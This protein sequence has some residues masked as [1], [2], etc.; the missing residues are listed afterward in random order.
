MK[1]IESIKELEQNLET[2]EFYLSEGTNSENNKTTKLIRAGACFVAYKIDD[3]LRFAPSRFVGYKNNKLEKHFNS[4]KDGR[5][6]NVIIEKLLDNKLGINEKLEISFLKYCRNL[7]IEPYKKKRKYWTHN[8]SQ[9]F[10]ANVN[11]EGDFPE[12]R[13]IE[14]KH[15]FR[16][17]NSRVSQIAK[18]NFK[19]QHGR[20][21]CQI[22]E[23]DF[24]KEY[25][26]IGV[27]FIEAHHTIPVSEM[28]KGHLTKIEDLAMLC[29]N[30]H[31]MVHK[32]RPWL[33]MAELKQ[34]RNKVNDNT[35]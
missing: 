23:F 6:T 32:R 9:D 11:L 20:L 3:E 22:C 17:R 4:E 28:Q 7:G 35:N 29:S 14:R 16:E 24:E 31:K 27:D 25:G 33:E 30:C 1:H 2:V 13:I 26:E 12:G 18:E 15:K 10:K 21:F 19:N 5:E 8:L 34:L